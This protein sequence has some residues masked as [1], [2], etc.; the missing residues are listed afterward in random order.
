MEAKPMRLLFLAY[1]T[2]LGGADFTR[3][4]SSIV[5]I[6]L[7]GTWDLVSDSGENNIK[8]IKWVFAGNKLTI[9]VPGSPPFNWQI[10]RQV[11]NGPLAI[12]MKCPS[13]HWLAIYQIDGDQLRICECTSARPTQFKNGSG[14]YLLVFKRSY[15]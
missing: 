11:H 13:T 4:D 5:R 6:D 15:Q 2:L 3:H 14:V 9:H 1:L 7:D 10:K 12:D 8:G